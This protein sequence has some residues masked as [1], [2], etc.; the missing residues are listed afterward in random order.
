MSILKN[1]QLTDP[2]TR[3]AIQSLI[4]GILSFAVLP[5]VFA[6]LSLVKYKK[7]VKTGNGENASKARAGK[8][9][10]I[11]S[12]VLQAIAIIF[13]LTLNFGSTLFTVSVATNISNSGTVDIDV[14]DVPAYETND[15]LCGILLTNYDVKLRNG[16]G[17]NEPLYAKFGIRDN[18]TVCMFIDK[19]GFPIEGISAFRYDENVAGT[20]TGKTLFDPLFQDR[21]SKQ[22]VDGYDIKTSITGLITISDPS[23]F[24]YANCV[25]EN[26]DLQIY[27][28]DSFAVDLENGIYLNRNNGIIDIDFLLG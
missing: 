17:A 24:L 9:C 19:E 4:F 2:G 6:I 22:F 28:G 15:Y 1:K 18:E 7:Y 21:G 27:L 8:V 11:I 25:Y 16:M 5:P 10:G 12:L 14:S 3:N 20:V 13:A 23:A 26:D